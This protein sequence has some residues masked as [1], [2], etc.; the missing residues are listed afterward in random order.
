MGLNSN[1]LFLTRVRVLHCKLALE[2]FFLLH[3]VLGYSA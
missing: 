1:D 2:L 3:L